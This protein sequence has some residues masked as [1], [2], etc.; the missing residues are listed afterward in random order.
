[1]KILPEDKLL[2]ERY[3]FAQNQRE[4]G[5]STIPSTLGDERKINLFLR[6]ANKAEPDPSLFYQVKKQVDSL[7]KL[8]VSSGSDARDERKK[9]V[10]LG[11][12]V[13]SEDLVRALRALKDRG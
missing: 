13:N 5:Y 1:M 11:D 12:K 10:Q 4:Q 7:P 3:E 6:A 8:F 9:E 2:R